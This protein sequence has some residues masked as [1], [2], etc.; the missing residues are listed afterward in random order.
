MEPDLSLALVAR[1][2]RPSWYR[3]LLCCYPPGESSRL[4]VQQLSDLPPSASAF[5]EEI[6]PQLHYPVLDY[7]A[8]RVYLA[9]RGPSKVFILIHH[10]N[11]AEDQAPRLAEG[12]HVSSEQLPKSLW[13]KRLELFSKFDE[14]VKVD[15][16]SWT[17][18]VME[19]IAKC[20]SKRCK[21]VKVLDAFCGVG[22]T[23]IQLARHCRV[24]ALDLDPVK[25]EYAKHNA[26]VY[27]VAEKMTFLQGD[28]MALSSQ[29]RTDVVFLDLP[30]SQTNGSLFEIFASPPLLS[31]LEQAQHCAPTILLYLPK[32]VSID[33]VAELVKDST[34]F[35]CAVEL[36][37]YHHS[38]DVQ[39]ICAVIGAS[40]S[41]PQK[42]ILRLVASRLNIRDSKEMNLLE[43]VITIAGLRKTVDL[44][45]TLEAQRSVASS[46][47]SLDEHGVSKAS[48][49]FAL[50]EDDPGVAWESIM[51]KSSEESEAPTQPR[52]P[53]VRN[54]M[55]RLHRTEEGDETAEVLKMLFTYQGLRFVDHTVVL[56][57]YDPARLQELSEFGLFPVCDFGDKKLI[58]TRPAARYIA[59]T[60]G[61]Y[62]EDKVQVYLVE[63]L[64]DYV[65][66][67]HQDL[68][69]TENRAE[70]AKVV[71]RRLARRLGKWGGP[72]P[73]LQDFYVA[74]LVQRWRSDLSEL[75]LSIRRSV[76]SVG[77]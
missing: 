54:I 16:G 18:C 14:G 31:V 20:I 36:E 40:A 62:P 27:G 73:F 28:F 74:W 4:A 51:R 75:P 56:S 64:C 25:V 23:A 21:N 43:S 67:A 47:S 70:A 57:K 12:K 42:D 39:G 9:G 53:P 29:L 52:S 60:F 50:A 35:E 45:S 1:E 10:T 76:E 77:K 11:L 32:E 22:G 65:Q 48:A 6:K 5:T 15:V 58:Q 38:G 46:R 7:A 72:R 34:D 30:R 59:Q 71:I 17:E 2:E 3:R 24:L 61:L 55:I 26:N 19:R 37:V 68:L 66:D 13:L 33:E 63:S 8:E 41:L 69:S 44:L 49:F